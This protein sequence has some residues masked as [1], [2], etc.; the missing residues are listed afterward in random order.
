LPREPWRVVSIWNATVLQLAGFIHFSHS[1][2][3]AVAITIGSVTVSWAVA[4]ADITV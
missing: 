3:K 1:V 4:K 2:L